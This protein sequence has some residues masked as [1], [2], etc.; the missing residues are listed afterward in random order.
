VAGGCFFKEE[1]WLPGGGPWKEKFERL[2]VLLSRP[3]LVG[4]RFFLLIW[5]NGLLE[6]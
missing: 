1:D 2:L 6:D 5:L 3:E 4:G